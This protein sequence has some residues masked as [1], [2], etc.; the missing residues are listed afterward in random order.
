MALLDLATG[1]KG[2]VGDIKN[3][4][5]YISGPWHTDSPLSLELRVLCAGG[6]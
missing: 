6:S 4:H 2:L 5:T 1:E 3:S